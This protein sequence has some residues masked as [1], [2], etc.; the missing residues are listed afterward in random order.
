MHLQTL[1]ITYFS[2]R[3]FF[4]SL[5]IRNSSTTCG[6]PSW[7]A[8][9]RGVLPSVSLQETLDKFFATKIFRILQ[10]GMHTYENIHISKINPKPFLF[11]RHYIVWPVFKNSAKFLLQKHS[12]HGLYSFQISAVLSCL[13]LLRTVSNA[14]HTGI[15]FRVRLSLL[16][17]LYDTCCCSRIWDSIQLAII[18][19]PQPPANKQVHF[20]KVFLDSWIVLWTGL[21]YFGLCFLSIACL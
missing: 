2:F 6:W 5:Q 15:C 1:W 4:P 9:C 7:Q 8:K 17:S 13:Q 12:T 10:R 19:Y 20:W 21:G 18:D 16:K 11:Y 3:L 14:I